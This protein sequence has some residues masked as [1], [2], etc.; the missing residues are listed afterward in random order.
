MQEN[1]NSGIRSFKELQFHDDFMFAVIMRKEQY[2]RPFLETVLGIKIKK[3]V[4]P[5]SQKTID[6]T[7]NGKSVRLDVYVNDDENTVYIDIKS[8]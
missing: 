4:Y 1:E 2:C 5:E 7:Q 3:I 6:L 8:V